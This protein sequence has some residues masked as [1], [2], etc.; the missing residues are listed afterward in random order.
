MHDNDDDDDRQPNIIKRHGARGLFIFITI[1]L[2]YKIKKK[3]THDE[4]QNTTNDNIRRLRLGN[5][6]I[7]KIYCKKA[8]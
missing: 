2:N 3:Y 4:L 1:Y 6:R 8:I 5:R 7:N